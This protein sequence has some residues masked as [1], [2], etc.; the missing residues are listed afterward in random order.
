[1]FKIKSISFAVML[2]LTVPAVYADS[3]S[4]SDLSVR[5]RGIDQNLIRQVSKVTSANL[6]LLL[7][8]NTSSI[9]P[10]SPQSYREFS[11]KLINIITDSD[12]GRLLKSRFEISDKIQLNKRKTTE[13][14]YK[15]YEVDDNE[16]III[17]NQITNLNKNTENLKKKRNDIDSIFYDYFVSHGFS[18][19][20]QNLKF[21]LSSASSPVLSDFLL[22]IDFLIQSQKYYEEKI[23][24][25]N[26]TA[27][28]KRYIEVYVATTI[29]YRYSM[30]LAV[31]SIDQNIKNCN[32]L[33]RKARHA[34]NEAKSV[35]DYQ[36]N[37]ILI[38]NIHYNEKTISLVTSYKNILKKIK[39]D[40]QSKS[41][42]NDEKIFALK[43]LYRTVQIADNVLHIIQDSVAEYKSF[44][45]ISIPEINETYS[46]VLEEEYE[47][48]TDQ[49]NS[50][51]L[52][53]DR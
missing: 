6:N 12:V 26:S 30:D 46:I 9:N 15:L 3:S 11:S 17:E 39:S 50:I 27:A 19:D 34:I 18:I 36:S 47:R 32:L 45:S 23:I 10:T 16:K 53:A 31:E 7:L 28:V 13:L 51:Q 52:N 1:M 41:S 22:V 25:D 43:N 44:L 42:K 40:L 33:I 37:N 24:N 20:R 8:D 29:A 35:N 49:L 5:H 21:I 4:I 48:V 14:E 2:S 38:K